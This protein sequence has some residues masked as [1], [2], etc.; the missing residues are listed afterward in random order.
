[1]FQIEKTHPMIYFHDNDK[2]IYLT[3]HGVEKLILIEKVLGTRRRKASCKLVEIS[4]LYYN[5]KS[6][7]RRFILDPL[8]FNNQQ[9][10]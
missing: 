7:V 6:F 2:I 3:V 5:E 1:M 10:S 8:S 4:N 9:A